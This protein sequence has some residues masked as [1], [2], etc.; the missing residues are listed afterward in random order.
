MRLIPF[1]DIRRILTE[2]YLELPARF[3]F[4]QTNHCNGS[5]CNR[6]YS[7]P[8]DN[9]TVISSIWKRNL[10]VENDTSI[11]ATVRNLSIHTHILVF[12][13]VSCHRFFQNIAGSLP[14]KPGFVSPFSFTH[15]ILF[16]FM[17]IHSSVFIIQDEFYFRSRLMKYVASASRTRVMVSPVCAA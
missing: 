1:K 13:N 7:Y 2:L 11:T 8:H 17:F 15:N 6:K 16:K 14:R 5:H 12:C 9:I 10:S 3:L 4:L